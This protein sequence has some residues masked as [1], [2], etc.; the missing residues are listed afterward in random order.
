MRLI[1]NNINNF[2][3]ITGTVFGLTPGLHGFHVHQFGDI[4]NRCKGAGG[5]YNPLEQNH[6]AANARVGYIH[7]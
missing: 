3:S 5:H 7:G 2:C 6:G 4:S 1:S